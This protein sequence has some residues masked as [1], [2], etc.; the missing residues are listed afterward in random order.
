[1]P[2]EA[3]VV[4]VRHS[5][6]PAEALVLLG[7]LSLFW[8]LNWPAMKLILGE[9]E[10]WTYRAIC[11]VTGAGGLLG[12][13]AATGRTLRVPRK[14]LA[15]LLLAAFLNITCWNLFTAYGLTQ[16]AAGRASII[17]FTMPLWAAMLGALVLGERLL[18][19]TVAGLGLGL[20]AMAALAA[21]DF[22]A[23][24]AAAGGSLLMVGAAI[25]WAC[26]TIVLKAHRWSMDIVALAG[27]QIL[28]GGS[29]IALGMVIVGEP[30]TLLAISWPVGLTLLFSTTIPVVLCHYAWNRI[31]SLMPAGI[32]AVGTL[33]IPVVGVFSSALFL[34]E[35]LG[36][37]E[38]A[39]LVLVVSGL[40]L[41]L[42]PA[43]SRPGPRAPGSPLPA[44]A[45]DAR[46]AA[47]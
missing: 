3:A 31:V 24:G 9:V 4:D 17:A 12:I 28:I 43:A 5:A 6:V 13:A 14:E 2:D 38:L 47:E 39:A 46:P 23:I 36:W 29:P 26:G 33:M 18:P 40:F 42:V 27:W 34:G 19:R 22:D 15:P 20:A 16:I 41:V 11:F 25:A 1:M 21:R 32:A 10:P 30:S 35:P 37:T 7:A 44:V 8:G 45:Q